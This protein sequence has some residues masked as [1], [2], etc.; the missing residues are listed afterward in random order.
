MG[1]NFLSEVKRLEADSHRQEHST[2]DALPGDVVDVQHTSVPDM[3]EALESLSSNAADPGAIE[4]ETEEYLNVEA[5]GSPEPESVSLATTQPKVPDTEALETEVCETEALE[6][7]VCETEALETEVCE[8]EAL[9]TKVRE[10]EVLETTALDTEAL[11]TEAPDIE[12]VELPTQGVQARDRHE[13]NVVLPVTVAV[14]SE[15]IKEDAK[16]D[17]LSVIR[18]ELQAKQQH[19]E[20]LTAGIQ[21]LEQ[22][23]REQRELTEKLRIDLEIVQ[24]SKMELLSELAEAKRYILN[25]TEHSSASHIAQTQPSSS[26]TSGNGTHVSSRVSNRGLPPMST[27]RLQGLPPMSSEQ[28][29]HAQPMESPPARKSHGRSPLRY[30]TSPQPLI[31]P[32]RH[33]SDSPQPTHAASPSPATSKLSEPLAKS[34]SQQHPS[35]PADQKP[36]KLQRSP[37][38]PFARGD[39]P[40]PDVA[41]DTQ[42]SVPKPKLSDSDISWFD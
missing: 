11:D 7:E 2:P 13:L 22:Q 34:D 3:P 4:S 9:E 36:G 12:H 15:A 30:S 27:E 18:A 17:P 14:V 16:T 32:N 24:A 5:A 6:T 1:H 20:A 23:L 35:I 29:V 21:E 33:T 31:L 39:R 28:V 41:R 37:L 42:T 8:T 25:L 10:T 19:E 26:K 38:R 40:I